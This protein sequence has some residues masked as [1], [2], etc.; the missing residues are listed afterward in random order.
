MNFP[1]H[2]VTDRHEKL[3]F[4]LSA[5]HMQK[6]NPVVGKPDRSGVIRDLSFH[7]NG[8]TDL[9]PCPALFRTGTGVSNGTSQF[10]SFEQAASEMN[11][12]LIA[13]IVLFVVALAAAG[14]AYIYPKWGLYL[15]IS[16]IILLVIS[17][18]FYVMY[19]GM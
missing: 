19:T 14:A 15:V 11:K 9:S 6:L 3:A 2:K 12:N 5:A 8:E 7:Q 13:A 17:G 4:P 10:A 1:S 18:V 16:S